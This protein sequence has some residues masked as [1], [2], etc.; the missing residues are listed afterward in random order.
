[1]VIAGN[2]QRHPTRAGSRYEVCSV[3][4]SPTVSDR[5]G[6]TDIDSVLVTNEVLGRI[7]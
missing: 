4:G 2:P 6:S 7:S 3:P 5:S 1:V